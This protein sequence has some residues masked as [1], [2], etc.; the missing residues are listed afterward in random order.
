[1]R[2]PDRVQAL[3]FFALLGNSHQGALHGLNDETDW[4]CEE[5]DT[6]KAIEYAD[7]RT[8]PWGEVDV[9]PLA[10]DVDRRPIETLGQGLHVL[11][12]GAIVVVLDPHED[13]CREHPYV[14]RKDRGHGKAFHRLP[15]RSVC[16][17]RLVAEAGKVEHAGHAKHE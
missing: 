3:Q 14:Q 4:D 12:L 16:L 13:A 7:P 8:S 1:M 17:L 10:C 15:E 9:G 6:E 11:L 5:G 2:L